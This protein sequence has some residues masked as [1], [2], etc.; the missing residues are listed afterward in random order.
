MILLYD[1]RCYIC[2]LFVWILSNF[3]RGK[4]RVLPMGSERAEP[5]EELIRRSGYDPQRA[6]WLLDKNGANSGIYLII[7]TMLAVIRGTATGHQNAYGIKD[8]YEQGS[9]TVNLPCKGLSGFASRIAYFISTSRRLTWK[10]DGS[11]GNN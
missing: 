11:F 9:C 7:S 2:A 8:L 10:S 3:A 6:A 1:K 5:F 4:I